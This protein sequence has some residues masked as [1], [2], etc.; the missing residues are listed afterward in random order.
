MVLSKVLVLDVR[1]TEVPLK[2]TEWKNE[3][4]SP[5]KRVGVFFRPGFIFLDFAIDL[6]N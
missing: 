1:K 3:T 6:P 2:R 5:Y 4:P